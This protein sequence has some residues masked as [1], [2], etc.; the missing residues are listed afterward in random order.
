MFLRVLF[1]SVILGALIV[2]RYRQAPIEAS[3]VQR[4]PYLLLAVIYFTNIVYIF[5]LKYFG[6]I[7]SQAY[8]QLLFDTLFI[9]VFIYTTG[10][11]DSIFSFLFILNIIS[12]GIIFY[13]KG[14][15]LI[16]SAS[17][18]LYGVMLDLH[19]YGVIHPIESQLHYASDSY[20]SAFLFYTILVNMVAF[21]LVGYLSGFL[22]EQMKRSRAEL[23]ETM[24]DLNKLEALHGSIINS[25]TS[26]LIVVDDEE[27][28]I[29]FNPMAE[30]IL[31]VY[32]NQIAGLSLGS[33]LP[34]FREHLKGV[35]KTAAS[36]NSPPFMDVPYRKT[37][38]TSIHLRLSVS[39]LRHLLSDRGGRVIAFQ[40]VTEIKQIEEN[41]KRVEGLALLGEMAAGIAHE[42]RN[43]MASISGSIEILKEGSEWDDTQKRLMKIVSREIDRLNQLISDFLIFARPKEIKWRTFDLDEV[44]KES[45]TLFKNSPRWNK[46]VRMS[47][48]LMGSAMIQSD[49]ALIKQVL[50]NLFLN[51][52]DAMVDGGILDIGTKWIFERSG[53]SR[54]SVAIVI[55]DT[56]NGFDAITLPKL[57]T[58][59]FTTK[60]GGSG[61]GLATVK[62]I[63]EQLN[64]K[65]SGRNHPEGGAEITIVLPMDN[66]SSGSQWIEAVNETA[67]K[68]RA[69]NL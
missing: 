30:Q 25:I 60:E 69:Q 21:Y 46:K 43:P 68:T 44:I 49:P 40:D 50:W 57:F 6:K 22:A 8:F 5:L 41:M 32:G 29:L 45:L 13:R 36:L 62:R 51:A 56:G 14:G 26:G 27:R 7:R 61:L 54:K 23:K 35:L 34:A 17:S 59:F 33:V 55:R 48:H 16:A 31:G 58:P 47:T 19:Y 9:T 24:L 42:I 15:I 4:A 18:I 65:I 39:P 64:G 3:D 28:V 52:S 37:D 2:I 53:S 63:V 1:V 38:G 11:I 67:G 12:G 66:D 20:N 10:G